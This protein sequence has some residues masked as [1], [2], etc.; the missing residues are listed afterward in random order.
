MTAI[1]AIRAEQIV[2]SRG[3]P[4]LLA[5]VHTEKAQGSFAVPS[6]AST[7]ANEAHEL[8]DKDGGMSRAIANIQ[9]IASVLI[10][11]NVLDQNAVDKTM[12]ELDGTAQKTHL[13]GNALIGV[14]I[15]CAKAAAA[16]QSIEVFAHLR[17]L[18]DMKPS[19]RVPYLYM[20]FINGGKHATT[21][22]AFQEHMVVPD[23]ESV[24]DSLAIVASVEKHLWLILEKK[25]GPEMLNTMGD[26]GGYVLQKGDVETPFAILS[27]AIDLSGNAG[28]VRI[29]IDVAAS[30]FFEQGAY[31]VNE[32]R[33]SADELGKI[34]AELATKY[35]IL[36]IE[37]PYEETA[38]EDF[39]RLQKALPDVRVV[40]DDLTVTN[41]HEIARAG[42]AH[43]IRAVI[44]KPNQVGTLTETLSAMKEARTRDIDCIISH[45]SGDT[46][47]DFIADLAFAFGAFGMK[48]GTLRRPE[49]R[50]KYERLENISI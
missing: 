23:A 11:M 9:D 16:A 15:A 36:S 3:K 40:G 22:L 5:T 28:R 1:T 32:Q 35:P 12:I 45:R 24:S 50:I 26:E 29:A 4:T 49:R 20:N 34:Y 10:G 27:E 48:A 43:A 2:D 13:G 47:D 31:V 21:P 7:G 17:T 37:D 46:T 38:L 30:S 18:A 44:I 39:A 6:G 8:R 19:R 42:A 14:S 41:A 25:Y 33:L